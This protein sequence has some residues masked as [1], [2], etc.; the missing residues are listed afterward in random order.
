[1]E[2]QNKIEEQN[3]TPN[4]FNN[5]FY[6]IS[7]IGFFGILSTTISKT[8]VLPLLVKNGLNGSD[9]V[10]GLISFF[11]PLAGMLF[12]FPIGILIDRLGFKRLMLASAF[13]FTAAPL[14]YLFVI[15]P[16]WLIPLRFFHGFATAILGPVAA[17]AI[18]RIYFKNK[19]AKLG[20]YS[21]ITLIGRTIA[22]AVGG[23]IISYFAAQHFAALFTYRAVYIAAFIA[24]LPVL[25]LAISLK[26]IETESKSDEAKLKMQD[27][28]DGLKYF[29]SNR[30]LFSTALIEM[31]IYFAYGILETFLPVYLKNNG[32]EASLIG[33]IF[34]IQIITLA[35]SKPLFGH[36]AD[37]IDKRTQIIIGILLIGVA[38]MAIVS[39]QNIV[40]IILASIIFGLGMS[41]ATSATSIYVA[42]IAN[43]ENLGSSMGALSSIMDVGQSSGPLIAGLLITAASSVATGFIVIPVLCIF[44]AV[45]FAFINFGKEKIKTI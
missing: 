18:S 7:L 33:L 10:L 30:L 19:G 22:P 36:M 38:S 31:A 11:S 29:F 26:K 34:S 32:Y 37:R 28:T 40:L 14:C 1:M 2:E 23:F 39:V 35:V 43:R 8:P 24:S 17:T 12:S 15:N 13:F 42:D 4:K 6:V 25:V 16:Y 27:F 9:S 21:S 45:Y 3:K 41:I 44:V 20:A 5:F